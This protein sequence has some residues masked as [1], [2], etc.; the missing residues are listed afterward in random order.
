LR[1]GV[2]LEAIVRKV[3]EEGDKGQIRYG[4]VYRVPITSNKK[5]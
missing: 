4:I 5:I 1:R 2:E 3:D